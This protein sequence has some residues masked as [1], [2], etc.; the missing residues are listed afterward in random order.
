MDSDRRFL[1]KTDHGDVVVTVRAAAE[2][3]LARDFVSL[4][5]AT[6]ETTEGISLEVPLR[7]FSAKMID[8]IELKGLGD[9]RAGESMR[10]MMVQEKATEDLRR[11]ERF[12]RERAGG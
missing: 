8:L 9:F 12:A 5:D 7:A 2:S 1:V 3:G 4:A 6:P 11:I 10:R